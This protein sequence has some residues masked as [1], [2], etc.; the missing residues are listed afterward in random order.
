MDGKRRYPTLRDIAAE[1]GCAVRT[2]S[3]KC[4]A[5]KWKEKRAAAIAEARRKIHVLMPETIAAINA[6]NLEVLGLFVD[7]AK[8]KL[9]DK[10]SRKVTHDSLSA[11]DIEEVRKVLGVAM[12][13]ISA[14]RP[15]LGQPSTIHEQ[16]TTLGGGVGV[17]LGEGG[18][19]FGRDAEG[20]TALAAALAALNKAGGD[21]GEG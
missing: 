20:V 21:K 10:R 14:Q 2:A 12:D 6:K 1:Y 17:A 16:R 7:L 13:A 4:Q 8:A 3:L 9:A 15:L 5:Q 11:A 18:A 19:Q